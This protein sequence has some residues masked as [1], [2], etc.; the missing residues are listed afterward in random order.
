MLSRI[1]PQDN[2]HKQSVAELSVR[3]LKFAYIVNREIEYSEFHQIIKYNT[4]LWGGKYN[5]FV[6]TDGDFIRSDW[7]RQLFF[8]DPDIIF[9]AGRVAGSII[10]ELR[11]R[12]QPIQI[13]QWAESVLEDIGQPNK[14]NPMYMDV[15]LENIFAE[16]GVVDPSESRIRYPV[17]DGIY[18]S[19]LENI[20]GSWHAESNYQSFAENNLGTEEIVLNPSN[21][22]EYLEALDTLSKWMSPLQLTAHYLQSTFEGFFQTRSGYSL[23]IST[24]LLDDLFISHALHWSDMMQTTTIIPFD[25]LVSDEDFS[26]L[27]DWFGGKVRGNTFNI[28]SHNL[29]LDALS[30][31]REKLIEYL[32]ARESPMGFNGWVISIHRCNIV[33][34]TPI[35]KHVQKRQIVDVL[36]RRYSFEVLRPKFLETT[37]NKKY[38]HKR[39][40]CDID[41]SP[42]YGNKNGFVPSIFPDLN[43]ILSGHSDRTNIAVWG[44][45]IRIRRDKIS[46]VST[47]QND[48]ATIR[49]PTDKR[50]IETVCNNS[51]YEVTKGNSAY[52]D[53]M[54][55]LLGGLKNAG[56]LH[57][58]NILGLFSNHDVINKE[59]LTIIDMYQRLKVSQN[60]KWD[61]QN[62]IQILASKEI[63][64][65]GYNLI[66][67]VCGLNSWYKLDR[68][69]EH[70]ICDGCRMEFQ[71]PIRLEFAY[72]LNR[73]FL[74]RS[75]H[76]TVTVLLTLLVLYETAIDSLIWQA[77]V[78]L[79]K[80]GIDDEKIEID[81]IAM[82][83]GYLIIAE[84]KN[85]FL[86]SERPNENEEQRQRRMEKTEEEIDKLKRQ[87]EREIKVAIEMKVHLFLFATLE[88]NIPSEIVEFIEAQDAMYD[89]LCVRL[90]PASELIDGK[91]Q[92]PDGE[93][94]QTTMF[95]IAG[96]S[97]LPP[98]VQDDDCEKRDPNWNKSFSSW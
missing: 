65:R 38:E 78:N 52:Y 33:A 95:N 24:G 71:L 70:M 82:C 61:F 28:I 86:P 48:L 34:T 2:P 79:S 88:E 4:S 60:D 96:S 17:I 64:L 42:G 63:L 62:W 40:M 97:V 8:H 66:C 30:R 15:I 13:W 20:S 39:W 51:D 22:Q 7:W 9:F 81:I 44:S 84:C 12:L 46:L 21:L 3:P 26:L 94:R 89:R 59:A 1:I 68:V 27:A 69:H 50:V 10:K 55:N 87:L 45:P 47:M 43:F 80:M 77:D 16:S 37:R 11:E 25:S 23:I 29:D 41:I 93:H 83:D 14:V 76:G 49:I 54:I 36:D 92:R 56:F 31:I 85:S 75:N 5:L 18:K 74:D 32:P 98:F 58:P 67:P 91:F 6:P 19:Y 57:N 72:R 90:L 35:V 53:G 73:L